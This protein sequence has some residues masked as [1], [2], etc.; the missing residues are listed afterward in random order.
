MGGPQE[1]SYFGKDMSRQQRHKCILQWT[2][3]EVNGSSGCGSSRECKRG[4]VGGLPPWYGR[5]RWE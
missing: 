2:G 5:M 1:G 3:G 4:V